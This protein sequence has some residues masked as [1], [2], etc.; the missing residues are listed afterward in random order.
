MIGNMTKPKYRDWA[1]EDVIN[2][3]KYYADSHGQLV[4]LVGNMRGK[5][6]GWKDQNG[7]ILIHFKGKLVR[8]HNLIWLYHTGEWPTFE[9][10]HINNIPWDN[11]IENLRPADRA[12]QGANQ[13]LQSRRQGKYKGVHKNKTSYYVKIKKDGKQYNV[14]SFKCEKEAARAYNQKAKE[15]FGEFAHLN[16]IEGG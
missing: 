3:F 9:L 4:W 12:K 2:T 6:A 8:A 11:R 10:D 7:Y 13:K 1:Q 5:V 14:G 15:F 16:E